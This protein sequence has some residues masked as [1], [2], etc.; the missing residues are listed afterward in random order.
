MSEYS[1]RDADTGRRLKLM[2]GALVLVLA[3]GFL[4]VR[5]VRWHHD[6]ALSDQALKDIAAPIPVEVVTAQGGQG[7]A[8]LTL[9]GQTAAWYESTIYARV[10]GY[11]GAWSADIGDHVQKGQV[12]ATIETPELDADLVAAKAKLR[13]SQAELQRRQAMADFADTTYAR[14]RDS[15]KGVVSE[16]EREDKKAQEA[17]ARANLESA[18][19]QIAVD[20]A[21]V[22]RLDSFQQFK[23]VTA[24]YAGTITERRIDIGDLSTP[25]TPFF[26]MAKA[27][28]IRIFV[29]V[30]QSAAGDLMTANRAVDITAGGKHFTGKTARTSEAIDSHART[31]R[32]EIDLPNADFSLPPGM[33]V[34]AAFKLGGET[35]VQVPASAM[36]FRS[37]GPHVAMVDGESKVH[38]AAVTIARDEGSLIEIGTGLKPGDKVVLNIS[39]QV[40]DGDAVRV[41]AIDG[42]P[43]S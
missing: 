17:E 30:P 31:F 42:K 12:L 23:Q 43:Q 14:W 28:P 32:A 27:D 20:Q 24:P 1:T 37:D 8:P 16:Q 40:A 21:A 18:K 35:A 25:T 22:D 6:G 29:D 2:V 39:N 36:L 34:E 11:V 4:I 5:V 10:Q 26:H 15:P 38:F 33:Y 19:A 41:T 7:G 9:P 13:A 3:T